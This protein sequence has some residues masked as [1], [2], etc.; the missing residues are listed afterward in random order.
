MVTIKA[1]I[2]DKLEQGGRNAD[3][4]I[5]FRMVQQKLKDICETLPDATRE[6]EEFAN[7]MLELHGKCDVWAG[8]DI[9]KVLSEK[10]LNER[11][12]LRGYPHLRH[13]L[14]LAVSNGR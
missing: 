12:D 10:A 5:V 7:A 1:M 9:V 13:K 3:D 14:V 8:G 4:D 2:V 11:D 6:G